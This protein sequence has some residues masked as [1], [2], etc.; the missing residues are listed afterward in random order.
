MKWYGPLT[1][2]HCEMLPC[3]KSS[4]NTAP[5]GQVALG[6]ASGRPPSGVIPPA[7]PVI[8][9]PPVCPAV[10]ADDIPADP[11]ASPPAPLP[12]PP[13]PAV[14]LPSTELSPLPPVPV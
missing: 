9:A 11:P 7:P 5:A 3:S 14:L 2:Y 4:Q 6:E 13:R 8:E 12:W 1:R 10:P